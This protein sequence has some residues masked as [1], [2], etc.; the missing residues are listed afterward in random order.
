MELAR[1]TAPA[2]PD[3]DHGTS[4]PANETSLWFED[5]EIAPP[6]SRIARCGQQVNPWRLA[7]GRDCQCAITDRSVNN[8][9]VLASR[10]AS[11]KKVTGSSRLATTRVK[12]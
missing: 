1:N 11:A 3:E 9:G 8:F 4:R 10:T 6:W 12:A 5:I 7:G 2:P